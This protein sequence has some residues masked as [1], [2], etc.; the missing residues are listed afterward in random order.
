MKRCRHHI[1]GKISRPGEGL[2]DLLSD[3]TR[4]GVRKSERERDRERVR[5]ERERERDR[6]RVSERER[7]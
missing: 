5:S 4:F 2:F 7:D 6:E 3:V 1:K